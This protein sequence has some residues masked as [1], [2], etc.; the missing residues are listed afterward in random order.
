[1]C[2]GFAQDQV[3]EALDFV[4]SLAVIFVV[5][6]VGACMPPKM[7]LSFGLVRLFWF[8]SAQQRLFIRFE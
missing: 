6:K 2:G 4:A 1:V 5:F 3:A 8:E 7:L